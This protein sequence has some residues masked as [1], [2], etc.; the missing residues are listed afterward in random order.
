MIF[1]CEAH[2]VLLDSLGG[3][4]MCAVYQRRWLWMGAISRMDEQ[5]MVSKMFHLN[6][7]HNPPYDIG[8]LQERC[9]W[10]LNQA[11]QKARS[12]NSWNR[13]FDEVYPSTHS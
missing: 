13:S 1:E 9:P 8:S 10:S 7:K 12:N 3:D 2:Q 5:R 6:A 4:L 11:K